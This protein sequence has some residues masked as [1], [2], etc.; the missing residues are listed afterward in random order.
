MK[1]IVILILL[2]GFFVSAY[3]QDKNPAFEKAIKEFYNRQL[4]TDTTDSFALKLKPGVPFHD[5]IHLPDL[6]KNYAWPLNMDSNFVFNSQPIYELRMP[7]VIPASP[8]NM[9]VLVPDS[10]VHYYILQKQID[11]FNPLEK[12]RK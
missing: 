3:A 7:V 9:P 4:K 2:A 8:D 10:S 11:Y 12:K 5:S 6:E 1:T